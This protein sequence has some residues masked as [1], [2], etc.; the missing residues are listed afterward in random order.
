MTPKDHSLLSVRD[1]GGKT[2]DYYDIHYAMDYSKYFLS[3]GN[4]HHRAFSHNWWGISMV[5]NSFEPI[6]T[7]SDGKEIEVRQILIDHVRQDCGTVP[8][9]QQCL[10]ALVKNEYTKIYN[11]PNKED[12]EWIRSL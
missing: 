11:K 8:T 2:N 4:A 10:D 1:Y 5:E 3:D 9:L 12:I 6:L 7:N